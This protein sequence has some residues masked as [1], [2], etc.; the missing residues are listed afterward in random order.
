[1]LLS[2]QFVSIPKGSPEYPAALAACAF[3]PQPPAD[4]WAAGPLHLLAPPKTG[5]FCSSQC[6]GAI[7]L[8]TFDAITRMRDEEQVLVGGFHS[9]MEWECLGILLR[10]R[11]PI[12]WVPARS[13]IGMRLKSELAPAF[14]SGRLLILSP[15]PPKHKRVTAALAEER[16]RFV[17][18][19]AD[20]IFVPNAAPSSRT[21]VL[22]EE[23]RAAGKRILNADDVLLER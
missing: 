16:N 4:L 7:I 2:E 3:L 11:Q 15:F 21:A 18:A 8:R 9:A 6:P 10:G 14:E 17:G 22:C 5:F 20:R 19:L 23:L 1:M 12:I 13:I